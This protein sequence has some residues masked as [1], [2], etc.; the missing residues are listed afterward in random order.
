[1]ET[2]GQAA[3]V[4]WEGPGQWRSAAEQVQPGLSPEQLADIEPDD[5]DD[6]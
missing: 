5:E 4:H 3:T 6:Q 1:M 2:D